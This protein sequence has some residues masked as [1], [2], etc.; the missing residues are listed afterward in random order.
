MIVAVPVP[1]KEAVPTT[2]LLSLKLTL[3]EGTR[4]APR[5]DS[6]LTVKV[7]AC[8]RTVGFEELESVELVLL[9]ETTRLTLPAPDAE[10]GLKLPSPP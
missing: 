9:R 3:P 7:I 1:S 10:D 8:P 6:T 4:F 5:E 2:E